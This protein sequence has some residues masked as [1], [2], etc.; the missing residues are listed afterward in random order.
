MRIHG[1]FRWV[2]GN[3]RNDHPP[4]N[5]GSKFRIWNRRWQ[6]PSGSGL[7]G[8]RLFRQAYT[9]ELFD[10]KTAAVFQHVYDAYSGVGHSVYAMA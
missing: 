3:V 6:K 5:G 4:E 7:R 9:P 1:I 10:Q 8:K 2:S